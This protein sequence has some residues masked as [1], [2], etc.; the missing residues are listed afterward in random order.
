MDDR[1]IDGSRL[2]GR[3]SL[4]GKLIRQLED[5]CTLFGLHGV[6]GVGKTEVAGR[7]AEQLA[8]EKGYSR[9]GLDAS[10][11]QTQELLVAGLYEQL[12]A[13]PRNK[14]AKIDEFAS[15]V[16][17][18]SVGGVR[19]LAAAAF[20]D[21]M[22]HLNV[23]LEHTTEAI[24]KELTG[25][26]AER[27]ISAALADASEGN[28]RQF[29][30]SYMEF[31]SNIGGRVVITIDNYEDAE[32]A[33]EAFL[34]YLIGA[35]PPDWVVVIVINLEKVRNSNWMEQMAPMIEYKSGAL[36][37]I[38]PPDR[39]A[40]AAWYTD[41]LGKEPN[42]PEIEEALLH[43]G[44]GRPAYLKLYFSALKEGRP[45]PARPNLKRLHEVR[46]I[47]LDPEARAVAEAMA[48]AR[49]DALVP[50]K[51]VESVANQL[52][53][54]HVGR[55]IDTLRASGQ[56]VELDRALRFYH[57][58]YRDGWHD[59]MAELDRLK[60]RQAWYR[61]YQHSQFDLS[62]LTRARILPA[63]ATDII[64]NNDEDHITQLANE[65]VGSG[66]TLDALAIVDA[67]WCPDGRVGVGG[68]E[69]I[70]HALIAAQI[71]LELGRYREANEAL[72]VIEKRG[73]EDHSK[74]ISAN[75]IRL[76][77]A[78][79]QNSY[80]TLWIIAEKL[81]REALDQ[82][83]IQLERELV[84]NTA[85]RDLQAQDC[86]AQ[87]VGWLKDRLE[88]LSMPLRAKAERV[89]ARSLA[90]LGEPKDALRFAIAGL[91]AAEDD[92]DVRGMGNAKLAVGE[93]YR[94][95]RRF[96]DAIN[97]YREGEDFARGSGN[98]D[99]E[100]WCILGRACANLECGNIAAGRSAHQSAARLVKEPGF[101]H[102]L[103]CAH[104][105]L[106]ELLAQLIDSC[107]AE[108]GPVIDKYA[109]IGIDWPSAFINDV[110][111]G[112]KLPGPIPI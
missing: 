90:K 95:S 112:R 74:L 66:N 64:L 80:K 45:L 6:G 100:I 103:E 1:K 110:V 87:S 10:D 102:P 15:E 42:S 107:E 63:L 9:V 65:L 51:L 104:L 59:G 58:S 24:A 106:V 14:Q 40:I 92:G 37:P 34:Q 32:P 18:R 86:L 46:R 12:K 7:F 27:G 83:N 2:Y 44:H 60:L 108:T 35:K 70:E 61:V 97:A 23:Q 82:P 73:S 78:L 53:V 94:Y 71:R 26:E 52:G 101:D 98:R 68:K 105:D 36:F 75:L 88:G 72:L 111:S 55:V 21:L 25:E 81:N 19:R 33:A 47:A 93:A 11:H 17:R 20:R 16:I 8:R 85:Y 62:D 96:D 49:A 41:E 29:I 5:G 77:L 69:V 99:G 109:E 31:I 43:T 13:L 91:A 84:V 3:E 4:L 38:D 79:R 67:S 39:A 28:Q 50:V 22:K 89:L 48:L 54:Q 76:K 30:R 57:S 56:I